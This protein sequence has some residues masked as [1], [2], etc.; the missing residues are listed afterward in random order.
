MAVID[1]NGSPM[2][3]GDTIQ[4]SAHVASIVDADAGS[5]T[6]TS[7]ELDYPSTTAR[8]TLTVNS[9]ICVKD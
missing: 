7:N 5:I 2:A 6:V 3:I 8:K 9:R 1:K 4:I